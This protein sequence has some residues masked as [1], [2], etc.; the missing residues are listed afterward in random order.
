MVAVEAT[1]SKGSAHISIKEVTLHRRLHQKDGRVARIFVRLMQ[2][3]AATEC[4]YRSQ[5]RRAQCSSRSTRRR[6]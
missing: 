6:S 2:G 1:P 4:I 5:A 3:Q